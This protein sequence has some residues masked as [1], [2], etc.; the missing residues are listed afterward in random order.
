MNDALDKHGKLELSK[1]QSSK[2][3]RWARP[4][5]FIANPKVLEVVDCFSVKQT[6]VSD[7]SFVASIAISAQYEKRFGKKIIT[8]LIYPQNRKGIKIIY[9]YSIRI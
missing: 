3:V 5:E 4:D 9:M 1:K 8:K 6:V 2:L 7:C